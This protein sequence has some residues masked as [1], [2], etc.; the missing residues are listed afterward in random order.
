MQGTEFT[1]ATAFDDDTPDDLTVRD[2][3]RLWQRV[4]HMA[5]KLGAKDVEDSA[6]EQLHELR[7]PPAP[8]PAPRN[9]YLAAAKA[10]DTAD[11]E[12][13]AASD[14]CAVAKKAWKEAEAALDEARQ[15]AHLASEKRQTALQRLNQEDAPAP[16]ASPVPPARPG[17]A[18]AVSNLTA[19]LDGRE[20]PV[21][22]L[23]RNVVAALSAA[24]AGGVAAQGPVAPATPVGGA[25]AVGSPPA[26]LAL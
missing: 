25:P 11:R 26:Q 20:G 7:P 2:K 10:A 23:L 18:S 13:Q 9:A 19:A 14:A 12:L 5:T 24:E 17:L 3:R 16:D 22:D 21:V 15:A 1:P 6:I 8:E 4:K